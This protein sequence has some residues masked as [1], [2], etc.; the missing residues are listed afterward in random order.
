VEH[1]GLKYSLRSLVTFANGVI[2][3]I[4]DN[5]EKP[6]E[7]KLRNSTVLHTR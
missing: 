2:P 6:M 4:I 7:N 3:V 1:L 5:T